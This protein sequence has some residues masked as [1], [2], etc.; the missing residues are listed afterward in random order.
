MPRLRAYIEKIH[1]DG[2]A[3]EGNEELSVQQRLGEALVFGLRILEGVDLGEL[4]L[5]TG[6]RFSNEQMGA[7]RRF[8]HDGYF[9][10][11]NGRLCV[12]EKGLMVLDEL[13]VYLL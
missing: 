9:N 13:S 7:I 3:R 2:S 8:V 1:L 4:Q 10:W 12:M 5:K 11:K 6:A